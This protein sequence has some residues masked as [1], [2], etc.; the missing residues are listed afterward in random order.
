M[1]LCL[2][3]L[4]VGKSVDSKGGNGRVVTQL[5]TTGMRLGGENGSNGDREGRLNVISN[6]K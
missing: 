4:N 1:C 3:G 5:K 6:D 2:L